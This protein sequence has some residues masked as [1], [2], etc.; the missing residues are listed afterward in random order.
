MLLQLAF[1]CSSSGVGELGLGMSS[2]V[3]FVADG[4]G[5]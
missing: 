4:P 5:W 1:I 2:R 3:I